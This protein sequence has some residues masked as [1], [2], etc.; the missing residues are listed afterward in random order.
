M[1][2]LKVAPGKRAILPAES[3]LASLY[4]RKKLAPLLE[5]RAGFPVTMA[6]A[7]AVI[8]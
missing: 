3:T 1:D 5:S 4:M 7:Y 8:A 6:L 2:K